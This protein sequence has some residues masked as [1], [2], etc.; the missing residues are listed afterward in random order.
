[1]EK[2]GG[3]DYIVLP[4]RL[5]ITVEASSKAK[6]TLY[7]GILVLGIEEEVTIYIE[8]Y[9][10]TTNG[11]VLTFHLVYILIVINYY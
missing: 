11:T 5:I 10:K 4:F 9:L 1:M 8:C 7:Y 6:E 3:D 2:I